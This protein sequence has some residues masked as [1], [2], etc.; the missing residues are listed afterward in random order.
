VWTQTQWS[1]PFAEN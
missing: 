1:V